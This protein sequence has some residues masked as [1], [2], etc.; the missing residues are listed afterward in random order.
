[1]PSVRISKEYISG[2]YYL[3]FTVRNWYYLFDR[4]HRFEILA[5]SL[6][7]CQ[8][9]KGLT[10]YA[11]VF[12]LNHIHLIVSAPDMIAFVRDFKKFTSKEM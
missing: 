7:Y 12:M 11:Y 8:K 4:H 9:H 1:M 3:T 5:D 6:T 2:I 10:L